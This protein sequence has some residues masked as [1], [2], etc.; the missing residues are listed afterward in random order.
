MVN[1]PID[2]TALRQETGPIPH[3]AIDGA[4]AALRAHPTAWRQ[5]ADALRADVKDPAPRGFLGLYLPVSLGE[6]AAAMPFPDR[7]P[8]ATFLLDTLLE[9]ELRND[10]LD[11]DALH[12]ACERLGSSLVSMLLQRLESPEARESPA[13]RQLL[14]LAAATDDPTSSDWRAFVKEQHAYWQQWYQ[15]AH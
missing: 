7:T 3:D 8:I 10:D 6:A 1:P 15:D 12:F 2:W 4:I 9:A 5:F 14:R 11:A 13:L